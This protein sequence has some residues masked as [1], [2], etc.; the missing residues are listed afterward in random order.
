[1]GKRGTY[2]FLISFRGNGVYI[3]TQRLEMRYIGDV[4]QISRIVLKTETDLQQVEQW[5]QEDP[6]DIDEVP[7]E[8]EVLHRSVVLEVGIDRE[9]AI[10]H[11]AC[12]E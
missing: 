12:D 1:M 10:D 4:S 6:H 2:T 8:A 5:E 3:A 7:V 9:N 11:E